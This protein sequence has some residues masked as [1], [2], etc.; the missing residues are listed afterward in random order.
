MEPRRNPNQAHGT[1]TPT[2]L[3]RWEHKSKMKNQNEMN[4]RAV[5]PK[6]NVAGKS[7]KKEAEEEWV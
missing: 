5:E 7:R 6:T 4:E 2:A 3:M 1:T